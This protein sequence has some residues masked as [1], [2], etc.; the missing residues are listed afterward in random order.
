VLLQ[1]S[2]PKNLTCALLMLQTGELIFLPEDG[3]ALDYAAEG[4]GAR[5]RT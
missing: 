4:G 2:K 1:Q 3:E 5:A